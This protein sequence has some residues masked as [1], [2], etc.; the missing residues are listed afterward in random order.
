MMQF[1]ELSTKKLLIKQI[2]FFT[3]QSKDN[4]SYQCSKNLCIERWWK[5]CNNKGRS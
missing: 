3:I 1:A 5:I 2:S 4:N